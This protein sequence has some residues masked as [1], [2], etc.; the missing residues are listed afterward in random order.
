[1]LF[2]SKKGMAKRWGQKDNIVIKS[3]NSIITPLQK[4][5]TENN[6]GKESKVKESKIKKERE[7]IHTNVCKEK[8]FPPILK[9]FQ[10]KRIQEIT[11]N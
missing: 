2:R 1:M 9:F 11:P 7:E 3:D 4:T 10:M 5:I 6:K 8:S